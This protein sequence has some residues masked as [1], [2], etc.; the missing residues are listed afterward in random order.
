MPSR[1]GDYGFAWTPHGTYARDLE[2]FVK[3]LDF[4]PMETIL[5]ATAGVAKLFMR[6]DELGK[7][8][9]GYFADCV[10]VDGN[11]LEDITVL[12]DHDKLNVIMINGRLHKASYKEFMSTKPEAAPVVK[13]S[14]TNYASFT[15]TL[16]RPRIGH[17]DVENSTITPLAMASGAPIS[18][19]YEVIELGSEL[20]PAGE[21]I[22]LDSVKL[23][24]P[25]SGRDVLAVGKNY[26]EH[27]KEFNKSGYDASDK[28]D[29]RKLYCFPPSEGC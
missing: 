19:L 2:H 24:P 26:S 16:G 11:P 27:A 9:P 18:T 12:Q 29:Q 6:E 20:L 14:L 10:L 4:T 28:V 25:I 3:L 8:K 7:I 17:L 13:K 22:P 23:L 15:D 5:A 1:G 21:P